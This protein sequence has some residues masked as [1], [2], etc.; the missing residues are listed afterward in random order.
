MFVSDADPVSRHVVGVRLSRMPLVGCSVRLLSLLL[1]YFIIVV[2]LLSDV[3]TSDACVDM[4][5]NK[6]RVYEMSPPDC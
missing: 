3:V 2:G 5:C 4:C 1:T 6:S